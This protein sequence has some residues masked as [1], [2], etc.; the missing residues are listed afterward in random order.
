M[1]LSWVHEASPRWNADKQRVLGDAAPGVFPSLRA[2]P[3]GADLPGDWWRVED[4]GQVVAFGWMDTV[5]GDAEVLLA[6]AEGARGRGVGAF[7]VNHLGKEADQRGLRYLHNVIPT[8]HPDP[9][10][11]RAW[12]GRQGFAAAGEGGLLRR[13]VGHPA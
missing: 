3:S 4:G 6:V 10:G 13:P 5:W 7:V 2:L 11:L 1:S 9:E 8:A 12:L